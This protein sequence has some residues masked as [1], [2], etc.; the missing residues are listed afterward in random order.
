MIPH[1]NLILLYEAEGYTDDVHSTASMLYYEIRALALGTLEFIFTLFYYIY[2]HPCEV[3][4]ILPIRVS[5]A[6]L[7]W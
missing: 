7:S 6:Y 5:L 2:H 4:I 1:P 3:F